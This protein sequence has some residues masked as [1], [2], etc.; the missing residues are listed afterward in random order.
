MLKLRIPFIV[1]LIALLQSSVVPYAQPIQFRNYTVNNGLP[2]NT[3]WNILQDDKGFMWFGTKNGLTKFDGFQFKNYQVTG[4]DI[5]FIHSI[6][7]VDENIYWVG[8]ESG[9]YRLDLTTEQ[10]QPVKEVPKDIVFSIITD[11]NKNTWV[12]TSRYGVYQ[13]GPSKKLSRNFTAKKSLNSLS[14]NQVRRLVEDNDGRIWMGTFGEGIDIYDPQSGRFTHFKK[15]KD[16]ASLSG[17]YVLSLY[18]DLDG[19]VWAGTLSDGLSVWMKNEN[20]FKVYRQGANSINDN[21][22]RAIYQPHKGEVYIGTEHGL[23]VLNTT[24]NTFTYYEKKFYD[25][26]SISDNSVYS[27]YGDRD[28]G[29]WVGTYFG[30]VNYFTSNSSNFELFYSTGEQNSLTG[31]AVSCFLEDKPGFFWVGT[32]NGGLNY[33]DADKKSFLRY[34][35]KPGQ[36]KLSHYNIH[37]LYKDK[38]GRLWI[39]TFT[40]GLNIYD[41]ANGSVK[42][43]ISNPADPNSIS[44]NSVY[45]IY[46]DKKGVIWIGTVKGLNVYNESTDNFTR[47]TD[48]GLNASCIYELYE[49][50]HN[51]FWI[52]TYER[53]LVGFNRITGKWMQYS[54]SGATG[55]SSNKIISLLDDKKD[56]LWLGMDGG[57]LDCFNI[58]SQS[59]TRFG[60]KEGIP[61]VVYGIL[62]DEKSDLWLSTNDGILKFSPATKQVWSY[63]NRDNLQG[64]VFNYNAYYKATDGKMFF[65]GINGFNTF[66]SQKVNT[67]PLNSSIVL[68]N[69]K[70]F[71]KEVN[72]GHEGSPLE[73]LIG[74]NNK[75]TLKHNQDVVTF[76][77]ATLNYRDPPRVRYAYK[78]EGFDDDWNYVNNQRNATYTNLPPGDYIFQVKSTDSFGNWVDKMATVSIT[79]KPPFYRTTLAYI[80][81]LLAIGA[82]IYFLR[83]LMRERLRRKNQI[84]LERLEVQKEH[85]FYQQK[86]DFFTTMAHEIRTPLSLIMAPLEKLQST[87]KK[88]ETMKQLN[89]MEEN[90]NRLQTLIN[91]LFDFR[92][93]ESD[94]YIIRKET[95][96]LVSFV[97]SVYSRFSPIAAQ[98]NIR[99]ALATDF[100]RLDI[101]ADPEALQKILNNLLINAFKFAKKT[102]R[103]KVKKTVTEQGKSVSIS[104]VDDGIGIPDE[105]L[106]DVFKPFFK[107]N[108]PGHKLRNM[109]GT[110]IGLSLAKALTEKHEGKLEVESE[111]DEQTTFSL[112]IPYKEK[113]I[114]IEKHK[115][116]VKGKDSGEIS[117]L[118]VEDDLNMLDYISS[119]LKTEG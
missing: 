80:F 75:I 63:S 52:A 113:I 73:K 28:G 64:K 95:I 8:T 77:Y 81:Y 43:Y 76:E 68:T 49:D 66:F 83:N 56:N 84:R 25:P 2:S 20:R 89:V 115:E 93:I 18:K 97:Q 92:R 106:D 21:I 107:V 60:I 51:N 39:G 78:M 11:R 109:S 27:I 91:Q 24:T 82:S 57:G 48:Q 33:F 38:K 101:E 10:F 103:L 86:M 50:D 118:I 67:K 13:F 69:F 90:T 30:G 44:N 98:R 74:F 37:A 119:S 102:V 17:N 31:N 6:C 23:N 12:S 3:T 9:L 41:P 42:T 111:Q 108:S 47:V 22:V 16:A 40:G 62:S 79:V 110:G 88:T 58:K 59:F 4:Q 70:L 116:L 34:P 29:I 45:A 35:F 85:E 15:G 61:S 54:V 117:I 65:G 14:L 71:N 105:Q 46:E 72:V 96:E 100:D 32:E 94:I 112:T 19:N 55:I 53:G 26:Y 99:F 36:Q 87:E 104:V 5:S 114:S 7:K 1:I